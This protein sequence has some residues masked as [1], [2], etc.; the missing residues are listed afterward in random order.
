MTTTALEREVAA[1]LTAGA[2]MPRP[3]VTPQAMV[4][5]LKRELVMRRRDY[6]HWG[7]I[8]LSPSE[9]NHRIRTLEAVLAVV[10]AVYA[11]ELALR[12]STMFAG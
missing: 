9:A 5:E 7:G 1:R 12:Q 6:P 10:E 2:E 3:A 4:S 11:D 8:M